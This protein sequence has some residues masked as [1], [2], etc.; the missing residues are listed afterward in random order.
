MNPHTI[1]SRLPIEDVLPTLCAALAR[2]PNAVLTAPPGAG[3]T[4]GVPPALLTA[5]WLGG[6]KLLLLEPRR[7]AARAAAHRM[8]T[9]MNEQVGATVGYRMR[10]DSK[11]GPKTRIEVVTEGI[12]TRLLQQDPSLSA[13]G[14]VLFDEFH[15]RSLQADTG[16]ALCLESQRLFRPDLR[17]LVMSATL[18][19]EAIATLL[20]E[21]PVITCEGRMFPVETRYLEQ[22][23]AGHLDKAVSQ[24]IRRSLA[25]DSGSLLV[26]LPGMAEIRRVERMLLEASLGP[27]ILVAPLH[28][29]L[30]QA[31]QDL[32]IAPAPVGTRKVVLATSIAETSL[33]IDGVRVVIDAGLLRVPR[34]DP[35]TGLTRLDTIRVTQDSADQRRGRAGRLEPGV[36]YRLWTVSEQ[37]A[38][39]PRRPPEM[40][41]ADLAPLMLDLAL[42]GTA[43]PSELSWLTPPPSGTVAQANDLLTRL[44]ALD[45]TGAITAHGRKMADLPIHPR[46]AHMLLQSLP[47]RLTSLACDLA[48]LLSER[49]VLRGPP[50]WRN[51][52]LRLRLDL[53]HGIQDHAGGAT[54]DRGAIQR[55]R[56]T[57]DLWRHHLA[58]LSGAPP[59]EQPRDHDAAGILLALA[60]PDRIAQRQPGMDRRYRMA[61]GRGAVFPNPDPLAGEP[62]LVIAELDGATQWAR[63]DLAAPVTLADIEQ[64]YQHEIRISDAVVWDEK[65]QAVRASRQRQL[66][67]LV[68][69]EQSLSKPEPSLIVTAL[70]Q[71]LAEKGLDPLAWTPELQQWRARVQFLR[72]MTG[73]E[74]PWPDLSNE[75]LLQT[76]D[77]WL[78]P[79]LDGFTTL[80]RVKR[81]DLTPPLHALLTWEQQR[82]LERL[83]PA[84]ITVPSGSHVRLDYESSDLP[85]LAVR[86]QEMFGCTDTP[87]VLN[88]KVP[89]MLHLLS[90]ARRP[91]QV[92]KDLASFWKS[93]YVEVKKE[94]RG[95]YPK[96]HWPDDPLTAPPTAKAKRRP[97]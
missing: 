55:I 39:T 64:L 73:P 7:L 51:A 94:L 72:R 58:R 77:T 35:R 82:Q 27:A 88:G 31:A 97:S 84:Q 53:L 17:L 96:H 16:L 26:F 76:L 15:E 60:Y 47:L 79:Y 44:G 65:T 10:L 95:R 89:V 67:S 66:W 21:A 87:R 8:A 68:L 32:A 6:N 90:P 57:A 25:Q 30:P 11:I 37:A 9:A 78:G 40:L 83:A 71:G 22:P 38:L 74:S 2:T 62:Y 24:M 12:L 34:F 33:T 4:T 36:C 80:E 18:D 56:R 45:A 14:A 69:A 1:T 49:D 52:D 75:H 23:M 19:V 5:S 81:L 41:D 59:A 70:L 93:A 85:V 43:D 13:Y 86:L 42:W 3:K 28:G 91:V 46:L 61:N 50:G 63:I 48:A 54:V 29:D 92:T 20:G